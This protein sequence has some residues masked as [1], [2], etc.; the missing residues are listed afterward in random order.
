MEARDFRSIGRAT[1]E[2]LRRRALFLIER[3]GLSQGRAA[4]LV[5]V[6]RQTVNGWVKRHRERG[7]EGVLD[8]RRVSSR[9]GKGRLTAEEADKVR[10]WIVGQTPDQLGLPF[11]LW[12]SR[13]ARELTERRF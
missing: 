4:Q 2:E 10:A 7:E 11:G 5:G 6:H 12:T 3:Q 1:Q 8:G 13:A 9:R